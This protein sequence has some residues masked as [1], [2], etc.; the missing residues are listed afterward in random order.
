MIGHFISK[1]FLGFLLVGGLAAV[2]NFL[3]RIL[4]SVWLPFSWA[5]SI[6]Y[7]VG[8]F[9]AFIL[10][11]FF[12]FPKS[13]KAKHLQARDFIFVNLAFFPATWFAAVEINSL[14]KSLGLKNYSE[15]LAHAAAIALPMFCTFLIYKFFAF[16]E[17]RY[18]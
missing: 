13:D 8:M 6:A 14:L 12:I 7:A 10:N 9:V 1:Q 3:S 11:S 2:L 4:F 17:N 15:E 5:V 18:G 16:K